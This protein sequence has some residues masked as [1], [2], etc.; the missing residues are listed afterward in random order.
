VVLLDLG[1]AQS[2][3]AALGDGRQLRQCVRHVYEVVRDVPVASGVCDGQIS[4]RTPDFAT[5]LVARFFTRSSLH[6]VGGKMRT[7]EQ[8]C[9]QCDETV[10]VHEDKPWFG[11][12]CLDCNTLID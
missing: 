10:P 12:V 6:S 4:R 9:P 11:A 3:D 8:H 2:V 7:Q 5:N 1:V